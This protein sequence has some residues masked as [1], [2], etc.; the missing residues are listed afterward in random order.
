MGLSV[1]VTV[2]YTLYFNTLCGLCWWDRIWSVNFVKR[3]CCSEYDSLSFSTVSFFSVL[4]HLLHCLI[5][6]NHLTG[7]IIFSPDDLYL[8]LFFFAG[9]VLCFILLEIFRDNFNNYI[10][11]LCSKLFLFLYLS[12]F[13]INFIFF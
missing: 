9:S 5:W 12:F 6:Q 13:F 8:F 4:A 2:K 10:F 11:F 1:C 3:L 7:K